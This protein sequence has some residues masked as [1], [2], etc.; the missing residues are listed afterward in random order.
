MI[1]NWCQAVAYLARVIWIGCGKTP[2]E[3]ARLQTATSVRME[4][5]P[6]ALSVLRV[7]TMV[8]APHGPP[9][10]LVGISYC[11]TSETLAA[12]M[13]TVGHQHFLENIVTLRSIE[14]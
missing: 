1:R 11:S 7:V 14:T 6:I 5:Q 10:L 3:G 8:V 13:T 2:T 12:I 4:I 9:G